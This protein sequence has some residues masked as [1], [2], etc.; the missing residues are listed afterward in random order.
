MKKMEFYSFDFQH[1]KK[2]IEIFLEKCFAV[3]KI[4]STF[5]AF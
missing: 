5:V 2:F 3:K 1:Y 4:V